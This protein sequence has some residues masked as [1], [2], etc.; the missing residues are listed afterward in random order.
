VLGTFGKLGVDCFHVSLDRHM[1][2]GIRGDEAE[3]C[4]QVAL[5]AFEL[6]GGE[7]PDIVVAVHVI[8]RKQ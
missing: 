2:G 6:C 1:C 3:V 4:A 8:S 7:L 5:D